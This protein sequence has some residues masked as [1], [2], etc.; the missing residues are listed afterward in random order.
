MPRD[1]QLLFVKGTHPIRGQKLNYLRDLEF[2]AG[3]KASGPPLFDENPM[4]LPSRSTRTG[5]DRE[6]YQPGA[7]SLR[8]GLSD[9]GRGLDVGGISEDDQDEFS[10]GDFEG[11]FSLGLSDPALPSWL[12]DGASHEKADSRHPV[13]PHLNDDDENAG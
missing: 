6:E 5:T 12:R 13:N 2:R 3:G 11:D 1:E 10:H 9:T 4:H 7:P 8:A